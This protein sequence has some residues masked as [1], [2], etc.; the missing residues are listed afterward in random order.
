[1]QSTYPKFLLPVG[2][3]ALSILAAIGIYF[4]REEPKVIDTTPAPLLID[5]IEVVKEDIQVSVRAQGTVM[6]RT[7]T[8]L[9]AE[10]SGRIVEVSDNFK[11][12]GYF[13]RGDVLLRIDQRD[14]LAAVKRAEAAVASARSN[15]ASEKGR[16]DVA[17]QDWLKYSSSV[18]R[19]QAA[20][21]LALRKPQMEEA[22]ARLDSAEADLD[23]ARDQLDRTTIRAPYDG[24]FR[25]KKVDISQY[26]NIGTLLAETFAVDVA[27][28]RLAL[29]EHKLNYLELPT[30]ADGD[31]K[32]EPA[33]QLFAEVNGQLQQWPAKIVRTE[34][35]FDERSRV[36]FAV[37]Q[38]EDPYAIHSDRAQELRI[39]T[40]VEA[41]IE[42]RVI[43]NLVSLPRHLLRAGNRVW[44]IDQQQQLQNREVSVLRTDGSKVYVTEGLENGE[45][46]C[47]STITGAVPGTQVRIATKIR[48][49]SAEPQ[50][51]PEI[52]APTEK[53]GIDIAPAA[54]PNSQKADA[55][56]GDQAV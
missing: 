30:L 14:Y 9:T 1:M 55:N 6:P 17:Y 36:L 2:I 23:H 20:T 24:L 10:V 45:L 32:I 33:V 42:G 29:P 49:D 12:G 47:A 25:S 7:A 5:A 54:Q 22:Q 53:P 16:A 19:S 28:L 3:I 50:T 40:F 46:V 37:A 44:V 26:V 48:S 34:G 31:L 41:N 38:I 35:V 43:N 15:L 56:N 13:K 39:G 4:T 11:V 18:K 27:E 21:D 8:N 51:V 52:N